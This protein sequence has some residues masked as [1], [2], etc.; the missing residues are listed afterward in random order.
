MMPSRQRS[1]TPPR[2]GSPQV[3]E[4]RTKKGPL[5]LRVVCR[6]RA[7][8]EREIHDAEPAAITQGSRPCELVLQRATS[9]AASA[10]PVASTFRFDELLAPQMSQSEVADVTLL[11]LVKSVLD[12]DDAA[13]LV[14]GPS[15]SGKTFT[16]EGDLNHDEQNGLVTRAM[17]YITQSISA[18][19]FSKSEIAFSCLEINN[20]VVTDPLSQH[21]TALHMQDTQ[22]GVQCPGQVETCVKSIDEVQ[23]LVRCVQERRRTSRTT[24]DRLTGKIC[25]HC[26]FTLK[27]TVWQP[28]IDPK[29]HDEFLGKLHIVDLAS[30]EP[31]QD[32]DKSLFTLGRIISIIKDEGHSKSV[33]YRESKLTWLLKDAIGGSQCGSVLITT[34]SPTLKDSEETARALKFAQ[35]AMTVMPPPARA[36]PARENVTASS[37]VALESD[38]YEIEYFRSRIAHHAQEQL[39]EQAKLVQKNR[40]AQDKALRAREIEFLQAQNR[41]QLED[42]HKDLEEHKY[43]LQK[44]VEFADKRSG[45]A[46]GLLEA[47]TIAQAR[48]KSL[49]DNLSDRGGENAAIRNQVRNLISAAEGRLPVLHMEKTQQP[50]TAAAASAAETTA[51]SNRGFE[52]METAVTENHRQLTGLAT[53]LRDNTVGLSEV[54]NN[55]AAQACEA[56]AGERSALTERLAQV[57]TSARAALAAANDGKEL[58]VDSSSENERR[59]RELAEGLQQDLRDCAQT[60]STDARNLAAVLREAHAS[61]NA[62]SDVSARRFGESVRAPLAELCA[63][64]R[65]VAGETDRHREVAASVVQKL[66]SDDA[67]AA[68]RRAG[69]QDSLKELAQ[70]QEVTNADV[71]PAVAQALSQLGET[72]TSRGFA[73]SSHLDSAALR[74]DDVRAGVADD[75]CAGEDALRKAVNFADDALTSAWEEERACLAHLTAV[76]AGLP[77]LPGLEGAAPA[78]SEELNAGA[79]L[80]VELPRAVASLEEVRETTLAE[81]AKLRQQRCAEQRIIHVLQSQRNDLE[82]DIDRARG[83]LNQLRAEFEAAR[84]AMVE[85]EESQARRRDGLLQAM[86]S[87]LESSL[88]EA[89]NGLAADFT[90]EGCAPVF[91]CIE[92]AQ[93]QAASTEDAVVAAQ[94][95][96]SRAN[97]QAEQLVDG[98][99]VEGEAACT[100]IGAAQDRADAAAQQIHTMATVA[101]ENLVAAAGQLERLRDNARAH[102]SSSH[103]NV[104]S[105]AASWAEHGKQAAKELG[106]V[107][108]NNTAARQEVDRLRAEVSEYRR[109][110]EVSGE[111][112]AR[113]CQQHAAQ[114]MSFAALHEQ[115]SVE[116]ERKESGCRDALLGLSE[117]L[118]G[119]AP[120]VVNCGTHA[121]S[122]EKAVEAHSSALVCNAESLQPALAGAEAAASKLAADVRGALEKKAELAVSMRTASLEAAHAVRRSAV[123]GADSVRR[124]VGT[125]NAAIEAQRQ[126]TAAA[127]NS[128]EARWLELQKAHDT[129][130]RSLES[131]T[132]QAV[133]AANVATKEGRTRARNERAQADA[134]QKQTQ[135]HIDELARGCSQALAKQLAQWRE[136]VAA[137]PLAAHTGDPDDENNDRIFDG[138][139]FADLPAPAA[140]AVRCGLPPR[141]SEA[142]LVA[143]FRGEVASPVAADG[144]QAVVTNTSLGGLAAP[145]AGPENPPK[146]KKKATERQYVG[147]VH[148]ANTNSGPLSKPGARVPLRYLQTAG[149]LR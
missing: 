22:Y 149:G 103:S 59:L 31:R 126:A 89:L 122:L 142:A 55:A 79:A 34:V 111:D 47:L 146:D 51:A 132:S 38:A 86:V 144:M 16:V 80:A 24:E 115:N 23:Q 44:T 68:A 62:N 2:R 130:I 140:A 117:G 90:N 118:A 28:T 36:L 8:T 5:Q 58:T 108:A 26:I 110:A 128:E 114:L 30:S 19:R 14:Y 106:D 37:L 127:L 120:M 112:V 52:A 43:I 18:G 6:V 91:R 71:L 131:V 85:V 87:G 54:V 133:N 147:K 63:Q 129:A 82:S 101:S 76:T 93:L 123:E 20:E 57:N 78:P 95:R 84:V 124:A 7:L 88:R 11:P 67:T 69:F 49:G 102:W 33:P 121:S 141:P 125:A 119:T 9:A 45:E 99:A 137:T 134:A 96:A 81:V 32:A 13:V 100:N 40:E 42:G 15:N 148:D 107:A 113:R 105:A 92:S 39:E 12:G 98:M 1:V 72:L 139:A 75:A 97:A 41:A 56:T 94:E 65:A 27:V 50:A 53:S 4:A 21:P 74:L 135:D 46:A 17:S 145:L 109:A 66:E 48:L 60:H 104:T 136:G 61:A 143:E 77:A 83:S 10:S 73:A 70:A 116:D 138:A 35:K 25:S 64:L 3:V 29:V